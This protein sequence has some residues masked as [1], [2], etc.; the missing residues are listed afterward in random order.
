MKVIPG[1]GETCIS[2]LICY[3]SILQLITL[4]WGC[5]TWGFKMSRNEEINVPWFTSTISSWPGYWRDEHSTGECFW[6]E[7]NSAVSIAKYLSVINSIYYHIS[8]PVELTQAEDLYGW[9]ICRFEWL[10]GDCAFELN[11]I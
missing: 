6:K 4:L 3:Y 10:Y 1:A 2:R 5:V 8:E 7:G 9:M 11:L